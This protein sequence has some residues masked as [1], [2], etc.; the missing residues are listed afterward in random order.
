MSKKAHVEGLDLVLN[1]SFP[2]AGQLA[3][4]YRSK[5][6]DGDLHFGDEL[7]PVKNFENVSHVTVMAAY[8]KLAA[9]GYIHVQRAKKTRVAVDMGNQRYVFITPSVGDTFYENSL[10]NEFRQMAPHN[11]RMFEVFNLAGAKDIVSATEVESIIPDYIRTLVRKGNVR[12]F[13][14]NRTNRMPG[15]LEFVIR[16]KIPYVSL[17]SMENISNVYFDHVAIYRDA[18]CS[19][20][21][22][23][24]RNI[25]VMPWHWEKIPQELESLGNDVPGFRWIDRE[26][27]DYDHKN[28]VESGRRFARHAFESSTPAPDGLVVSDDIGGLGTMI[29]LKE[30]GLKIP[31]DIRLLVTSYRSQIFEAFRGCDIIVT[32]LDEFVLAARALLDD[33]ISG[34]VPEGSSRAV[35]HHLISA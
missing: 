29:E 31:H 24:C 25:H 2:L 17:H 26:L 9:E 1:P 15:M 12:G 16:K 21:S 18:I 34:K 30:M 6:I 20:A 28:P 27:F 5:I 19:L 7:P 22:R 32:P 11:G 33:I 14:L 10:T 35:P 13:F 23:S 8:R 3:D 4:Y